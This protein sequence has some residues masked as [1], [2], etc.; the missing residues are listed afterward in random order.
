MGLRIRLKIHLIPFYVFLLSL[1]E[2]VQNVLQYAHQ[3]HGHHNN[4]CQIAATFIYILYTAGYCIQ[5]IIKLDT[6]WCMQH[7]PCTSHSMFIKVATVDY[8]LQHFEN[9][10]IHIL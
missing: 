1:E 8:V 7:K 5:N 4:Q 3:K 9:Q 6:V 2:V 10:K